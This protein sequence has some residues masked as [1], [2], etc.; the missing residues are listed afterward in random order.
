MR[1]ALAAL[2]HPAL[3]DPAVERPDAAPAGRGSHRV[4]P[5]RVPPLRPGAPVAIAA[6]RATRYQNFAHNHHSFLHDTHSF[7]SIDDGA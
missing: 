7:L 2:E 3:G 1:P 4:T 5:L 6:L